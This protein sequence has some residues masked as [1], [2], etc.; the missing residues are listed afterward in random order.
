MLLVVGL[1][2][3][4]VASQLAAA[5]STTRFVEIPVRDFE[6]R[7]S[8]KN[9]IPTPSTFGSGGGG[10]QR[11]RRTIGDLTLSVATIPSVGDLLSGNR[12]VWV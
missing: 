10:R 3:V 4:T 12:Y 7:R 9:L 11:E 6:R 2:A 8:G 5:A 1:V